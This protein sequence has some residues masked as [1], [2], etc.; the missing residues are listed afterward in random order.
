MIQW[1]IHFNS[2]FLPAKKKDASTEFY[3]KYPITDL[4]C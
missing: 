3:N 1:Q 4:K 2:H